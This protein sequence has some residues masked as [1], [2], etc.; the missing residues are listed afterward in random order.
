MVMAPAPAQR[1]MGTRRTDS[2]WTHGEGC[3]ICPLLSHSSSSQLTPK[4]EEL[5]ASL[6]K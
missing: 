4:D 2:E 1:E 6:Y 3:V 5:W